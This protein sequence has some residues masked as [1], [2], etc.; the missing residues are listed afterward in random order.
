MKYPALPPCEPLNGDEQIAL[1][2]RAL[3]IVKMI[4][5]KPE[6]IL[7]SISDRDAWE[8][9]AQTGN[10]AAVIKQAEKILNTPMPELPDWLDPNNLPPGFDITDPSTWIEPELPEVPDPETDTGSQDDPGIDWDEVF[11]FS[12]D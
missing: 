2:G 6:S 3:E 11:D 5:E 7:P 1:D 12:R 9:I 4:P 10:G 8:I